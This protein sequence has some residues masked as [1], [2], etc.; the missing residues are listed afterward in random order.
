M[1]VSTRLCDQC[2]RQI[3]ACARAACLRA[4]EDA[5]DFRISAAKSL[6]HAAA[7]HRAILIPNQQ[8]GAQRSCVF[9]GQIVHQ[10]GIGIA[11]IKGFGDAPLFFAIVQQEIAVVPAQL[12]D[13]FHIIR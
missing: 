8:N 6:Y 2:T 10:R 1:T 13:C 11:L 4:N 9:F 3:P 12:P 7:L 5:F